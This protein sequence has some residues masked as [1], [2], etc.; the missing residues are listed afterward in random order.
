MDPDESAV[1]LRRARTKYAPDLNL[2]RAHVSKGEER[3]T[4]ND[5]VL[6]Y[7]ILAIRF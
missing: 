7:L 4:S 3:L 1:P 5:F 6:K 2:I